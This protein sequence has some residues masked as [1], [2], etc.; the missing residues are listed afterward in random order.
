MASLV[1]VPAI[2]LCQL[3]MGFLLASSQLSSVA[4]LRISRAWKS[5]LAF[6]V[7]FLL[8]L[9]VFWLLA[10]AF[11]GGFANGGW[12]D[13]DVFNGEREAFCDAVRNKELSSAAVSLVIMIGYTLVVYVNISWVFLSVGFAVLCTMFFATLGNSVGNGCGV[14]SLVAVGIIVS[15]RTQ[16]TFRRA[17]F[18]QK[19]CIMF[20]ANVI[21]E[22]QQHQGRRSGHGHGMGAGTGSVHSTEVSGGTSPSTSRSLDDPSPSTSQSLDDPVSF[23]LLTNVK[24]EEQNSEDFGKKHPAPALSLQD[25]STAHVPIRSV[26]RHRTDLPPTQVNQ[27]WQTEMEMAYRRFGEHGQVQTAPVHNIAPVSYSASDA[28]MLC[29]QWGSAMPAVLEV[30]HDLLMLVDGETQEIIVGNPNVSRLEVI[31][32]QGIREIGRKILQD[33]VVMQLRTLGPG[34]C[35]ASND[36]TI[37]G[38]DGSVRHMKCTMSAYNQSKVVMAMQDNTVL[39]NKLR[40]NHNTMK[41]HTQIMLDLMKSQSGTKAFSEVAAV[42]G[43]G[44][45]GGMVANL[46][47]PEA[48]QHMRK[49]T[50]MHENPP[51]DFIMTS[52]GDEVKDDPAAKIHP[53]PMPM[54]MAQNPPMLAAENEPQ[55]IAFGPAD[56]APAHAL[57]PRADFTMD[58]FENAAMLQE[59]ATENA[60]LEQH[61]DPDD[62]Q[63]GKS[64]RGTSKP[65]DRKSVV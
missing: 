53:S 56:F 60:V 5:Q 46:S 31:L 61:A 43:M 14:V 4:C 28:I 34:M 52:A 58:D 8:P 15:A 47:Q 21:A 50:A 30:S 32:G 37:T 63:S 17:F 40:A 35:T 3:T 62:E 9:I 55:M 13:L 22:A 20:Q 10:V 12:C 36:T 19:Q 33:H 49:P 16:E 24:A 59:L 42:M 44:G 7:V 48:H 65:R 18:I 27:R 51:Q 6:L 29:M 38:I 41:V 1:T 39:F 25:E 2:A 45:M 64:G 54:V 23:E 26:K 11:Q 57:C